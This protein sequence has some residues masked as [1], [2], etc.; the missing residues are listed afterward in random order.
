MD[1]ACP[2]SIMLQEGQELVLSEEG[3]L[4]H[5][6][7]VGTAWRRSWGCHAWPRVEEGWV[8]GVSFSGTTLMVSKLR[9]PLGK[10]PPCARPTLWT[11]GSR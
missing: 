9:W 10:L 3:Q 1:A 2:V 11:W 6:G 7:S 5:T 8:Q 4:P